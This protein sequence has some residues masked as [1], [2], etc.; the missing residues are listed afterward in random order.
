[1]TS[2][3]V[4]VVTASSIDSNHSDMKFDTITQVSN[5]KSFKGVHL[6]YFANI[7]ALKAWPAGHKLLVI[8]SPL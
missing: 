1:M 3:R 8:S 2:S 4:D 7:T 6:A 5:V